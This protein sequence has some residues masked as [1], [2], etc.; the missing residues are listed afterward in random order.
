MLDAKTRETLSRNDLVSH[1]LRVLALIVDPRKGQLN[2]LAEAIEVHPT[3]LST[4]IEQGYVPLFQ[5]KKMER[6]FG[7]KK[8]LVDEL[9]PEEF[10]NA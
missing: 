1:H 9:C 10:R 8:V 7:K 3:T 4:W 2:R 6:R 5:C